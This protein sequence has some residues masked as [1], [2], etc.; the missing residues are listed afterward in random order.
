MPATAAEPDVA[1]SILI[2]AW[3][4]F[5]PAVSVGMGISAS[6]AGDAAVMVVGVVVVVV[7]LIT[8]DAPPD[9]CEGAHGPCAAAPVSLSSSDEDDGGELG[10]GAAVNG[11]KAM[12][13]SPLAEVRR[14][15]CPVKRDWVDVVGDVDVDVDGLIVG[16]AGCAGG[17][18]DDAEP[19]H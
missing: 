4:R 19:G 6:G 5:A 9:K 13:R 14:R 3:R 8:T 1:L 2:M 12:E 7:V 10:A 11:V 16:S 18:G 15:G 17:R